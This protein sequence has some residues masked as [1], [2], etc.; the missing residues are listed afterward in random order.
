MSG[1]ETGRARVLDAADPAALTEAA[2][3]LASGQLVA[4][5]TETVYGLGGVSTMPEA[6]ARIYAVKR[7]PA[8]NPLISHVADIDMAAR[9]VRFDRFSLRLAQAFWPGP[10]TLVLPLREDSAIDRMSTAGG[11]TAAIRA[12]R[13]FAQ[14]LIARLDLPLAMPSA[15]SSGRIS[16]TSARHVAE[17]LGPELPLIIDAGP[18]E[19]G[20]ESTVVRARAD[21]I[22]ILR[23]GVITADQIAMAAGV[24]LAD[25]GT[26]AAGD[27]GA[28]PSPGMLG[29]H[30]APHALL[31]LDAREVAPGEVLITF[32]GQV[33]PGQEDAVAIFDLSPS[34]DLAEAA[35]RLFALLHQA[36]ATGV[37]M[38]AMAPIPDHGIGLAI[39]DRLTR[40]AAPR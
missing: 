20:L 14:R 38:I 26:P 6:I 30:Y 5:P 9:Y 37:G 29:S 16:P 22:D 8:R 1:A 25:V 12:P 18:T 39:R 36:D 34:G 28:L 2:A 11:T 40:A 21:G 10:L 19:I 7:R 3:L 24:G 31:R 35:R 4:L 27:G 33:L 13:G 32:A 23:A 15:N 17:D